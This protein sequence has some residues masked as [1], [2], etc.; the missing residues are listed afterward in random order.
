[1]SCISRVTC[2]GKSWLIF[3]ELYCIGVLVNY[4]KLNPDQRCMHCFKSDKREIALLNVIP[5][6][7]DISIE[8][9]RA[10]LLH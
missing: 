10:K 7:W 1:M 3:S 4:E 8:I 9:R 2:L 5:F 6:L